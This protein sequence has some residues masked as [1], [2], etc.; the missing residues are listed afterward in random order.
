LTPFPTC[1]RRQRH[2]PASGPAALADLRIQ[3][4]V[5]DGI[6]SL[7]HRAITD[8]RHGQ[9]DAAIWEQGFNFCALLSR[10]PD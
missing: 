4:H 10:P 6:A 9:A 5:G 1:R 2:A 8:E 7:V 3:E